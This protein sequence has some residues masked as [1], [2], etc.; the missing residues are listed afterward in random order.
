MGGGGW[1]GG[2]V[3]ECLLGKGRPG[4]GS[5]HPHKKPDI[6]LS[7]C[8]P[9]TVWDGDRRVIR[10]CYCSRISE[11]LSQRNKIRWRVIKQNTW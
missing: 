8:K 9:N 7:A 6:A 5:Q 1:Q 4:F 2:E 11:R 10:A 3:G